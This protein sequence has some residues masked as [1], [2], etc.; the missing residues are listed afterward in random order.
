MTIYFITFNHFC[1]S[2]TCLIE[3]RIAKIRVNA[4]N[5][6]RQSSLYAFEN[7]GV[8]RIHTVLTYDIRAVSD[9]SNAASLVTRCVFA[10]IGYFIFMGMMC[11]SA[12][13]L[14]LAAF[15][16][17]SLILTYDQM[18]LSQ[19][20]FKLRNKEKELFSA[21]TDLFEGFKELRLNTQK[22]DDFFH[23]KFKKNCSHLKNDKLQ[24]ADFF[25]R[26]ESIISGLWQFMFLLAVLVLPLTGFFSE[27]LLLSFVGVVICVP[28][29]FITDQ[30]PRITLASISMKRLYEFGEELGHL[31]KDIAGQE[32]PIRIQST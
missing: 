7:F 28:V 8:E 12:F 32:T 21:I 14:M 3:D 6:I 1:K 4:T 26:S 29:Q 30:V 9:L 19:L 23:S 2:F 16:V 10:S 15:A 31:E 5:K 20:V 24:A 17:V 11:P 13:I 27:S 18:R 25:I 22:N